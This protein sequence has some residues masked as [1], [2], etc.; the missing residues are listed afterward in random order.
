M[1]ILSI[2]VGIKNMGACV[3]SFDEELYKLNVSKDENT[4]MQ[5][6]NKKKQIELND[7]KGNK[8]PKM[9]RKKSI[10][11]YDLDKL[12]FIKI[13]DWKNI[14][15]LQSF[16]TQESICNKKCDFIQKNKKRCMS[17]ANYY[18]ED[19]NESNKQNEC[20]FYC[21]KHSKQSPYFLPS[22]IHLSKK[23]L[24]SKTIDQLLY[25]KNTKN[26]FLGENSQTEY[27]IK[28]SIKIYKKD[29][30]DELYNYM[31]KYKLNLIKQPKCRDIN[32][33]QTG[34][35]IKNEFD[36]W[37]IG[38]LSVLNE[39]DAVIIENQITPIANRM[40][41]IQG[42]ISQYFIM[43]GIHNIEFVSASNK[44][45]DEFQH[46]LNNYIFTEAEFGKQADK[47]INNIKNDNSIL[48]GKEYYKQRKNASLELAHRILKIMHVYYYHEFTQF[49]LSNQKKDDLADS[50]L[51]GIWYI[52]NLGL[53]SF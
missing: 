20:V 51:Q 47:I 39:I 29:V 41:T 32:L 2:D 1:K 5:I 8:C 37:L 34:I 49:F 19:K 3:L 18:Y 31:N 14:N 50:L 43:N 9:H 40:K 30:V 22:D 28:H 21:N 23:S 42:M 16:I 13:V 17:T 4:I 35:V 25:L 53:S 10:K 15:I 36:R 24:Q 44:L 27:K 26:I 48:K 12:C 6:H 7:I 52:Y 33:I 38:E 45:N 11:N 46:Y